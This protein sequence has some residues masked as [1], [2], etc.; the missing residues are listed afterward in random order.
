MVSY[1]ETV[2]SESSQVCLSKST[3]KHNRI[4]MTASPLGTELTEAIERGD[5]KPTDEPKARAR[6]LADTFGW[7]VEHGRKIWC[8]GPESQGANILVDT[9]KGVQYL[10]EIRDSCQAAFQWATKEG[11]LCE[12]PMRGCRFNIMDLVLHGDA[13]HRGGGQIIPAVRRAVYASVLSASPTLQE[14]FYL[15]E[16]QSPESVLGSIHQVLSKRRAQLFSEEFSEGTPLVT[17]K[18]F[19]PVRESFGFTSALRSATSGLAFPQLVFDHWET[20]S[21]ELL[22]SSSVVSQI[23]T[24]K[25]LSPQ[26][27]PF[28]YFNDKL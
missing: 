16:I 28:E 10:G 7:D 13:L 25:G 6:S 20:M 8:F 22:N 9:T 23:R 11:V 17:I 1:R 15:A 2:L 19:L 21:P 24:R 26:P 18:A 4:Y 3:N 5:I 12:E 14:P 27:F